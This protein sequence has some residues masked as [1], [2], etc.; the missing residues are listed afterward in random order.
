VKVQIPLRTGRG[1]NSR[2]HH[3]A[4]AR[5]VKAEER[6]AVAWILNGKTRPALPVVVTMTRSAPSKGLDGDNLAGSLKAVRD[7]VAQ[8]LGVDD[9]DQRVTWKYGQCRGPWGV[10]VEFS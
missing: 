9:A 7:Q 6:N 8:W 3:F 1:L 10:E 5:R 4:R 2:E